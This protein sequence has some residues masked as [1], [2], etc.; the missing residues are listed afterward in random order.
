MV[1][2]WIAGGTLVVICLVVVARAWIAGV[3]G[4]RRA[5]SRYSAWVAMVLRMPAGSRLIATEPDCWTM[6]DIGQVAE[7]SQ[8]GR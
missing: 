2:L 8:E 1:L 4:Q 5:V 6:I 7:N 3:F